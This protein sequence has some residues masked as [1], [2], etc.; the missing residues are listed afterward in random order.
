MMPFFLLLAGGVIGTYWNA[1]VGI[2]VCILA[3]LISLWL[4]LHSLL[5]RTTALIE[6]STEYYR[7]IHKLSDEEKASL[8]VQDPP[9]SVRVETTD[10]KSSWKYDFLPISP[11]KMRTLAQQCLNGKPF[12]ERSWLGRSGLLSDSEFYPL[13]DALLKEEYIVPRS[14]KALQQ[15]FKWTEKGTRLLEEITKDML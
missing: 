15:G 8:G 3:G 1:S 14:D 6:A 12:S 2:Y 10:G 7:T 5:D 9:S 11:S 4:V 13:R